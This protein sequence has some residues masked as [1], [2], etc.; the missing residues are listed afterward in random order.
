MF[1]TIKNIFI[2]FLVYVLFYFA[3]IKNLNN[4]YYLCKILGLSITF[5]I[6]LTVLASISALFFVME[7]VNF[8][9]Y[10]KNKIKNLKF[11][12]FDKIF[13]LPIYYFNAEVWHLAFIVWASIGV[14]RGIYSGEYLDPNP[15]DFISSE[16]HPD[17]RTFFMYERG[18]T[19]RW[20]DMKSLFL[21]EDLNKVETIPMDWGLRSRFIHSYEMDREGF[22][23]AWKSYINQ[24]PTP[25]NFEAFLIIHPKFRYTLD[26]VWLENRIWYPSSPYL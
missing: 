4:N 15:G 5:I 8:L 3:I 17:G 13:V 10:F 20:N 9:S 1:F 25:A 19:S 21:Y 23:V 24:Q 14:L 11:F 22:K 2:L 26:H 7:I 16:R 12:I 18:C 6:Y